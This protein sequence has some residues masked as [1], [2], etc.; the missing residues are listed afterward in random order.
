MSPSE[1]HAQY[2]NSSFGFDLGYMLSTQPSTTDASGNF[3]TTLDSRPNRLARGFRFGGEGNFKL[4]HDKWWFDIRLG[5]E[6]PTFGSTNLSSTDYN[7]ASDYYASQTLGTIMGLEGM[8]GV[9]YY[10]WTDHVRPYLQLALSYTH[11]WTF[12]S[13]AGSTCDS[14]L[15]YNLCSGSGTNAATYLPHVNL[16]GVHAIPGIEFVVTRDF[17]IHTIFDFEY[18]INFQAAGNFQTTLG[19]GVIFFS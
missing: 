7:A 9:R 16:M 3:L 6:F 11:L 4:H 18:A 5:L 8:M 2:R 17:A 15:N 19:L 13:G 14:S 10:F 12:G 1:A